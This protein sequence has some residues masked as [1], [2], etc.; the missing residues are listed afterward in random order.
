MRIA[1]QLCSD[2]R[3]VTNKAECDI[4]LSVNCHREAI[5][6]AFSS[7]SAQSCIAVDIQRITYSMNG[8]LGNIKRNTVCSKAHVNDN[9]IQTNISLHCVSKNDVAHYNFNAHQPI[10]VIFGSDVAEGVCYQKVIC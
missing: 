7:Q 9:V 8:I 10:L 4:A 3:N 6:S 2:N 1:R 5:S